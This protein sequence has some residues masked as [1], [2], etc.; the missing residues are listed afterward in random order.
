MEIAFHEKSNRQLCENETIAECKLGACVAGKLKRRLADLRAATNVKEIVA[1]RQHLIESG[2]QQRILLELSDG[3]YLTFCS[4]H[5][6][7]PL[8]ASGEIDWS[9]VSRIKILR[10]ENHHD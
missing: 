10:I 1:G 7:P 4:N 6:S 8:L 3:Y 5:K 9:Q 2:L